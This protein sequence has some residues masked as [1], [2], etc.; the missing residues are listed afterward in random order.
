[1]IAERVA[2]AEEHAGAIA[3]GFDGFQGYFIGKPQP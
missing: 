2:N 1:V 3:L